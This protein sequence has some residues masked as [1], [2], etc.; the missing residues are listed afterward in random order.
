MNE[1]T[2]T[3]PGLGESEL[4]A[5]YFAPLARRKGAFRLLDD[6][7][8]IPLPAMRDMVATCDMLVAGRHFLETD[9]PSAV[10]KKALRVNLSDLAAKGADAIGYLLSLALPEDWREDWLQGFT[11]GLKDDQARYGVGLYGGDTVA[12]PGPLTISITAFGKVPAGRI[13]PR[14]QAQPGDA[15]CVTGSIGDAALG[16]LVHA[17]RGFAPA[18]RINEAAR[19]YLI[20]RYLFP[21]PRLGLGRALRRHA[22]A[23]MDISDGLLGD[24][25]K[26]CKASGTSGRIE[27]AAVPLSEPSRALVEDS[28]ELLARALTGG[29]DYELLVSLPAERVDGLARHVAEAGVKLTRIGTMG[30]GRG[31]VE[32]VDASGEVMD[33][34]AA[35]FD[36]F[37]RGSM[38]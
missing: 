37:D 2:D 19:A 35:S 5:T 4:I 11:F 13:V 29:D 12:T 17:Q 24:L 10:A 27:A 6:A 34:P 32:L 26:M 22:R 9:P 7:A 16:L 15:I 33:I 14:H 1:K 20:E 21:Q 30:E 8:V 25:A 23:A 28:P 3:A 31:E 38:R 36:H 18:T